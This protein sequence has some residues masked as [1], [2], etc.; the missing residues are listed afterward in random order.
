VS[1]G[2]LRGEPLAQIAHDYAAAAKLAH[3]TNGVVVTVTTT[4]I[5][6]QGMNFISTG[7]GKDGAAAY[8]AA[9]HPAFKD[10]LVFPPQ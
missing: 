7:L 8:I 9:H 2:D 10:R 3:E 6:H 5:Y 1:L 4:W